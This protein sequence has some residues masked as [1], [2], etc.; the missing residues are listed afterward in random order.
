MSVYVH[1][2]TVA[3]LLL[4]AIRVVLNATS[5]K[6][7]GLRPYEMIFF[8]IYL[9]LPAA[10][11]LGFTLPLTEISTRSRKMFVGSRARPVRLTD[12]LTAIYEPIV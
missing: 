2:L 3:E 6:V 1:Y 5:R 7:A 9:I 4:C 11:G 12:N 10:L 8:S